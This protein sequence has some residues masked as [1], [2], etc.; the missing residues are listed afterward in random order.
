MDKTNPNLILAI[1][2]LLWIPLMLA[3]LSILITVIKSDFSSE[4]TSKYSLSDAFARAED[5]ALDRCKK[6]KSDL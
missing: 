2:F 1:K 6:D 3:A 4:E 5:I